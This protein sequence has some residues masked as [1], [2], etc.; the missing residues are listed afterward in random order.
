MRGSGVVT[1]G[2]ERVAVDRLQADIDRKTLE[3]RAAYRFA[4]PGAP[5][6]LDAVLSGAE[7]DFDRVLA[8]GSA[9]FA[10]TSFERPGEMA[11]ALDIGRASKPARHRRS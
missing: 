7:L 11:L 1:L 2:R 6:R 3:G 10:S 5:A 8:I 9:L 4:T